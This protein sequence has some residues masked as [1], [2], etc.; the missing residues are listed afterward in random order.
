[1]ANL[2]HTCSA[3]NVRGVLFHPIS[4]VLRD[5]LL[6]GVANSDLVDFTLEYVRHQLLI[7]NDTLF[8]Y[9]SQ[10]GVTITARATHN[11][12]LMTDILNYILA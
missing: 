6:R 11:V 8:T 2:P 1:M 10:P 7:L 5:Y 12:R 9:G 3:D 4:D